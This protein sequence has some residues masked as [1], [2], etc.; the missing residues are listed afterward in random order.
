MGRVHQLVESRYSSMIVN[1][2]LL[3]NL[4]ILAAVC[5]L[6]GCIVLPARYTGKPLEQRPPELE[7]YYDKGRSY[8][9][10]QEIRKE[11]YDGYVIRQFRIS[12]DV[13]PIWIDF[14]QGKK[15]S[16][17][18][19]F[20]FPVLGG[21]AIIENYFAD[22]FA[23]RGIDAA[24]VHRNNEF[25]KPENFDKLEEL[26]RTNLVRDRIA[27]D[28]FEENFE[29]KTFGS[30]GISRGA[31]NVAMTAG[32][33]PRLQYNVLV[34]GGTD[35]VSL[36]RESDE[37]RIR[38]Y[39]EAV[40][41]SKGISPDQMFDQLGSSIRTDPKYFAH[42]LD[43]KKTLLIL[44]ALDSTVPF[45]Y[46]M[47]LRRQIGNPRTVVLL[48]THYT[49]LLFTQMVK[50]FPPQKRMC[51]FPFD[52]VENQALNF[53][54]DAFG[55]SHYA[56]HLAPLK[57]LQLPFNVFAAGYQEVVSWFEEDDDQD[58]W[59]PGAVDHLILAQNEAMMSRPPELSDSPAEVMT[60][61]DL[62][63]D[64]AQRY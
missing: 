25:K 15:R 11:R 32:V 43:P 12:S 28:F 34:L 50:V 22:Y 27:I 48:G 18:V 33:D 53:Y 8:T 4:L 5:L 7:M 26:F 49:S 58:G 10:V 46:G 38:N 56:W 42:Y 6:S 30:F 9:R 1:P 35:V 3:R 29:K 17:H 41:T 55:T 52:Y 60:P 16:D 39:V 62:S 40:T 63:S 44:A 20:V 23:S 14:F 47:K 57:L 45:K 59:G 54:D 2:F 51:I 64:S 61:I 13:G 31:I 19:V 24:I 21:K 37:K 36:F